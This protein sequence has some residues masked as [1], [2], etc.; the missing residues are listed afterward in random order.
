[1][2]INKKNVV[3]VIKAFREHC[4]T[5]EWCNE[6]ELHDFCCVGV[7]ALSDD[8]INKVANELIKEGEEDGM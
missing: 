4:K 7:S 5:K 3:E 2:A 8:D 1:M 6:C